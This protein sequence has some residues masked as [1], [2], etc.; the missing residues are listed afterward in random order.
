MR[1][2]EL[3]L[4]AVAAGIERFIR[5]QV[6]GA[7]AAGVVLGA[8]GG[9]D[10]SLVLVLSVRA[11]GP[12]LVHAFA[13]PAGPTSERSIRDAEALAG[14]LGASFATI[15]IRP[16]LDAYFDRFADADRVR[17]GN[18]AARERMSV[19]FD[20]A[21]ALGALVCGTSNKSEAL[22]GYGTLYGD[23]A[24]SLGPI[25]DLYKTEV[26]ALARHVGVPEGIC[27]KV[28]S[29]ELWEG[30]TDEGELGYTYEELDLLLWA[31]YDRGMDDQE[32]LEGG[33]TPEMIDTVRERVRA[34]EFKRRMPPVYVAH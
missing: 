34:N 8:S 22:L 6:E 7:S 29:A 27:T 30:Q 1:L 2:P 31:M 10:S 17:R 33:F 20:Q 19:L 12:E 24:W 25:G 16:E 28:P 13:L 14:S 23:A 4:D 32:L 11:L 15:D 26:K 18:K 9:V 5:E 21:K 3:D